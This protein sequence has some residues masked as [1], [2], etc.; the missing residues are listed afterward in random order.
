MGEKLCAL[1]LCTPM[2]CSPPVSSI[3]RISQQ[4]YWS[5]LSFPSPGDLPNPGIK[6]VSPG[7]A[8]RFFTTEPP[9][10]LPYYLQG[11]CLFVCFL[12]FLL[13]Y[14]HATLRD[15][16][17]LGG[18]NKKR[19]RFWISNAIWRSLWIIQMPSVMADPNVVPLPMGTHTSSSETLSVT[20][21]LQR[22]HCYGQCTHQLTL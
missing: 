8:G 19:W 13:Y 11:F 16:P 5:G 22:Y 4:E 21:S 7:L 9:E 20:F 15:L 1:T 14:L 10:K 2:D 18:K 12:S 17:A 6:S 3:H